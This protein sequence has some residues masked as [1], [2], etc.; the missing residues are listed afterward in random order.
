MGLSSYYTRAS[1]GTKTAS[2]YPMN[3]SQHICATRH[4]V[5][6]GTKL[7]IVNAENGRTS[8]CIVR[9]YGPATWT[10]RILD[11]SLI[12]RNELRFGGV[13]KVRIY[14]YVQKKR[15]IGILCTCIPPANPRVCRCAPL[16]DR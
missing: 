7:F 11:V 14:R 10:G 9:D 13:A 4:L 8:W 16:K 2:G 5:P 6:Y 1:S 15:T 3:D 12:V